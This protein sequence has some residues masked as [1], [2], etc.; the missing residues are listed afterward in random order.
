ME[1]IKENIYK[2]IIYTRLSGAAART[3]LVRK[4][5]TR[6]YNKKGIDWGVEKNSGKY[7]YEVKYKS[8]VCENYR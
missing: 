8:R 2:Y 5:M 7:T 6:M 4:K 3:L 1:L